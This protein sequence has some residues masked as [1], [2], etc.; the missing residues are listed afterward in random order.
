[1]REKLKALIK[2]HYDIIQRLE[3]LLD[4]QPVEYVTRKKHFKCAETEIVKTVDEVFNTNCKEGSRRHRV[5]LA[6]HAACYF[7]RQHTDLTL[8]EISESMGNRDHSTVSHSIKTFKNLYD[9]DE[10]Y[11]IRAD[12]VKKVL[13][14]KKL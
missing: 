5:A 11:R 6:R 13:E 9:T 2:S 14:N 7:L 1:L 12:K 3:D 8:K 4:A 10:G